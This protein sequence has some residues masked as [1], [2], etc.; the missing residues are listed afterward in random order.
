MTS[1]GR[2]GL[3]GL[4]GNLGLSSLGPNRGQ[5]AGV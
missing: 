5:F 1:F 4:A 2:P 3:R